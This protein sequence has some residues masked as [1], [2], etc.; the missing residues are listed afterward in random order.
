MKGAF[1]DTCPKNISKKGDRRLYKSNN[2]VPN[3]LYISMLSYFFRTSNKAKCYRKDC[4]YNY[5]RYA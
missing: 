1:W 5:A 2:A 4:R 3:I